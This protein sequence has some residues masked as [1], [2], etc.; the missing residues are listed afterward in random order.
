MVDRVTQP[1]RSRIMSSVRAKNTK[2]ELRVRSMAHA[3]GYR[4]RLHRADLP[5]KP[6][7]VFPSRKSVIF[8][9]GC[10]WH[11]HACKREKMPKSNVDFWNEKIF[12]NQSRDEKV[13]ASLATL[14]WRSLVIWECETKSPDIIMSKLIE[15]LGPARPAQ[16]PV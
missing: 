15:F 7:L 4:F 14:G 9:H 2:P 6:D 10:F 11:G 1:V 13:Q 12:N 3:L 16:G 5:G 8:V